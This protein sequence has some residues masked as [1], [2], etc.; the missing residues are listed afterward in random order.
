[1]E[2]PEL[3]SRSAEELVSG[4]ATGAFSPVEVFVDVARR[5]DTH[6]PALGA[7][8]TLCLER[9]GEEAHAAERVLRA[10]KGGAR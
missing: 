9:A 8:T 7:F 4:Y 5:I 1:M 10:R 2:P 3:W 6:S